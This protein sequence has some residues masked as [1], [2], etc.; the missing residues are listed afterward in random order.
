MWDILLLCGPYFW[1]GYPLLIYSYSYAHMHLLHCLASS[2]VEPTTWFLQTSKQTNK[3][4]K[5]A[6]GP[7]SKTTFFLMTL[8]ID[9]DH[10][11]KSS[12]CFKWH[13]ISHSLLRSLIFLF[14]YSFIFLH[15][16]LLINLS[17]SIQTSSAT[18]LCQTQGSDL[19]K[20]KKWDVFLLSGAIN[21]VGVNKQ[22]ANF[23]ACQ[24]RV[25]FGGVQAKDLGGTD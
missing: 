2:Q 20:R 12:T 17:H 8:G 11:Y 22:G 1:L 18:R 9:V 15:L 21:Q 5:F 6:K 13:V 16:S 23:D 24:N 19:G 14:S 4:K 7:L 3:K 10:H 25:K